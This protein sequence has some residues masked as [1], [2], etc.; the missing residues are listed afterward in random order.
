LA[1]GVIWSTVKTDYR[2][3]IAG[4]T[5]EQAIQVPIEDRL[6]YLIH[7]LSEVDGGMVRDGFDSMVQRWQYVDLL[8]ATMSNVPANRPFEDG[9]LMGASVLHVLQPRLLFPDKPPLPS[10]TDLA[11][12]YSG[13]RFDLG[14]NAANTSISLGYVAELYVDFGF[15][16]TLAVMFIFGL[17]FGRAVRFLT[18][19]CALPAIVNSG[20]ALVVMMS[21]LFFEQ[22][23]LKM[24]GAFSTTFIVALVLR[25]YLLP[26]LTKKFGP[27]AASTLG[28]PQEIAQM[29]SGVR[30]LSTRQ[31]LFD[32]HRPAPH[33]PT[34]KRRT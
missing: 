27:A 34:P 14:G 25:G 7:R 9:T 5:G 20:L 29:T 23:L 2:K 6:A 3:Y 10:D 26:Y 21:V 12:R 28:A 1:L 32:Q 22:A 13:I 18:S 17:I 19:P 15:V 33:L 16:G 4:G 24:I 30:G 11:V 8:A 31:P